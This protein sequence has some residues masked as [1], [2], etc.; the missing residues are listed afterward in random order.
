[1]PYTDPYDQDE[2]EAVEGLVASALNEVRT[3]MPARV[4]SYNHE[5]GRASV[6]PLLTR[7]YIGHDGEVIQNQDPIVTECPVAFPSGGGFSIH[8]PLVAGD[9]G[10][11]VVAES[12]L[13]EFLAGDGAQ[14]SPLADDA[15]RHDLTDGV[16]FPVRVGQPV[17]AA[18]A[19]DLVIGA[20]DGTVAITIEA[21][22]TITQKAQRVNHGGPSAAVALAKAT[23]TDARLSALEGFMGGHA[24]TASLI[25]ITGPPATPFVPGDGGASTASATVFTTS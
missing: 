22:G 23:T 21:D 17:A 16:F 10:L 15:R 19:T 14:V 25:G 1:M 11:L 18:N 7:A 12:S 13:E 4:V 9:L 24:H 20:N 5:T 2:A 6:Q 8:L 3:A